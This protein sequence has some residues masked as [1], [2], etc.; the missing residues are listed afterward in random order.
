LDG[1]NALMLSEETAI[2]KYPAHV[3]AVMQKIIKETLKKR[4]LS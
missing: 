4:Q 3:V 2:G 1:S